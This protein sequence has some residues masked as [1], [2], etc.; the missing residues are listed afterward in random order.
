MLSVII[1]STSSTPLSFVKSTPFSRYKILRVLLCELIFNNIN[2]S[3]SLK[4]HT[5][6]CL[7][8]SQAD[9][10]ISS[11]PTYF[12]VCGWLSEL[13]HFG[14][15]PV[16]C[17][18]YLRTEISVTLSLGNKLYSRHHTLYFSFLWKPLWLVIGTYTLRIFS[19]KLL[20]LSANGN[21]CHSISRQ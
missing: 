13:T 11:S 1:S 16:N 12:S 5:L 17:W 10:W 6:Y 9:I 4:L 14:F 2:H 20:I 7:C 8:K 19:G 15:F 21:I 3:F 18:S